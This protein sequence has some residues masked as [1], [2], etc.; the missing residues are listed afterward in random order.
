MA[1]LFFCFIF[2]ISLCSILFYFFL[3]S[4]FL[5]SF[6]IS[7]FLF[8]ILGSTHTECKGRLV[9]LFQF[10]N[11]YSKVFS[12]F[13][14]CKVLYENRTC[15]H[16]RCMFFESKIPTHPLGCSWV[17]LSSFSFFSLYSNTSI[18]C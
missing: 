2:T 18:E 4:T 5:E 16:L 13:A 15:E 6:S 11:D 10:R 17:M 1:L 8:T 3:K 7:C 9:R 12:S 14:C